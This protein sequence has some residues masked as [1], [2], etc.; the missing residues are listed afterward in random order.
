MLVPIGEE[1][2]EM[3]QLVVMALVVEPLPAAAAAAHSFGLLAFLVVLFCFLH[4]S[5]I[6]RTAAAENLRAAAAGIGIGEAGYLQV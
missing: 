3:G 4:P 2:A 5:P 6:H 1:E